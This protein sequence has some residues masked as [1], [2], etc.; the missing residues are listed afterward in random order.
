[1][2]PSTSA[3][4][5]ERVD[6]RAIWTSESANF[7]PW[8]AREDNLAILGETAYR[9]LAGAGAAGARGRFPFRAEYPLL[10]CRRG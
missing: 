3:L 2:L 9:R 4:C 8:L 7:T 1:M 5:L 6:L 10:R